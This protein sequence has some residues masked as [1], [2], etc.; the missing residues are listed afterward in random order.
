MSLDPYSRR[1]RSPSLDRLRRIRTAIVA[2][3][4]VLLSSCSV[5]VDDDASTP[6]PKPSLSPPPVSAEAKCCGCSCV[7]P[8]WSCTAG[9]CVDPDGAAVDLVAEAGFLEVPTRT[10]SDVLVDPSRRLARPR[11]RIFYSFRPADVDGATAPLIVLFNGGPGSATSSLLMSFNTGPVTL[12]PAKTGGAPFASTDAPWTEHFHLLFIDA[13]GTGFSYYLPDA[14][15]VELPL[16]EQTFDPFGDAADTLLPLL[17]FLERHPSLHASPLVLAGESY[18][19]ARAS[20]MALLLEDD[21]LASDLGDVALTEAVGRWRLRASLDRLRLMLIQPCGVLDAPDPASC[22]PQRDAYQCDEPPGYSERRDVPVHQ[23]MVDPPT[24]SAL[25]GADV[26]SLG[27][28]SAE[29]RRGSYGQVVNRA[30]PDPSAMVEAFGELHS[31][32][33]AYHLASNPPNPG[34]RWRLEAIISGTVAT[35]LPR[36]TTMITNAGLD[37]VCPL[38]S[39]VEGLEERPEGLEVEV[40]GEALSVRYQPSEEYPEGADVTVFLP[41][42]PHAGHLVTER[43]GGALRDDIR[44]WLE[45]PP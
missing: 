19:A 20:L 28:M 37:A 36:V 43:A 29:A 18:G 38:A 16:D 33:A 39:I 32:S 45:T 31:P 44:R 8:A 23:A 1:S 26:R 7:D 27:W 10:V 34:D 21:A 15:G 35:V 25:L 17:G 22:R 2:A 5:R 14:E 13:P 11:S 40:E 24:L 41:A 30:L 9:T 42:Y 3:A 12:D 4:V 6:T